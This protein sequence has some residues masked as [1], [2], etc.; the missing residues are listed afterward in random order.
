MFLQLLEKQ[1]KND[2][3]S[4]EEYSQK[5]N[6]ICAL[7][8]GGHFSLRSQCFHCIGPC[9]SKIKLD[10]KYY[11]HAT[12][13]HIW[14][15]D[16][17]KKLDETIQCEDGVV[18]KKDLQLKKNTTRYEEDWVTCFQCKRKFHTICVLFNSKI[19]ERD[20]HCLF[21]CPFCMQSHPEWRL[22]I[23][24]PAVLPRA[25]GSFCDGSR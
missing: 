3:W 14:C 20:K 12:L 23:N 5:Q 10:Q 8:E 4:K 16:C 17:Y 13:Q 11:V 2:K 21:V 15:E 25:E 6:S 19:A 7:C 18:L 24:V 9:H 22:H 1:E